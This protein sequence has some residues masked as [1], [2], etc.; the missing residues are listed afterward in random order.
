MIGER[1]S[2]RGGRAA[3]SY[4]GARSLFVLGVRERSSFIPNLGLISFLEVCPMATGL[5]QR[6]RFI[7]AVVGAFVLIPLASCEKGI[8]RVP[9][10]GTVTLDGQPLQGGV[11]MFY[12]DESKG[13]TARVG[14]SGP[15]KNGRYSLVTAGVTQI[16]TGTGAPLGWYNVTLLTDLPGTPEIKVDK[17]Y[18]R[19]ETTPLQVEIVENPPPGKYDLQLTK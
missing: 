3:S 14:C 7:V 12:P 4:F 15:V 6:K 11:L 19:P 17:K 10:S 18:L 8:R 2:G 1:T 16:D 13:N 9:V 5:V